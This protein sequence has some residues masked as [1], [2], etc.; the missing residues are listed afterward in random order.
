MS[1][2][3]LDEV[4][5][6]EQEVIEILGKEYEPT[7]N[8]FKEDVAQYLYKGWLETNHDDTRLLIYTFPMIKSIMVKHK[9]LFDELEPEDVFNSLCII[10][11]EHLSKYK[12]TTGK[13]YTYFTLILNYKIKDIITANIKNRKK[14][15]TLEEDWD[16]PINLMEA[17]STLLD[18]KLFLTDLKNV[19]GN[20]LNTFIDALLSTLEEDSTFHLQDRKMLI[21]HLASLT[22]WPTELVIHNLNHVTSRYIHSVLE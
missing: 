6:L 12:P 4:L 22:K 18:L 15:Y 13:L 14:H 19:S 9:K 20:T 1:L 5:A 7:S 21:G 11:L 3:E 8:Y 10:L 16:S 2:F 17:F